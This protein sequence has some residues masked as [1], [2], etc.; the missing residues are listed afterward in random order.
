MSCT[1]YKNVLK[2]QFFKILLSLIFHPNILHIKK[3]PLSFQEHLINL[4][5]GKLRN[6]AREGPA[7]TGP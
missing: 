4:L 2:G 6:D 7:I 1:L 5:Y 3:V